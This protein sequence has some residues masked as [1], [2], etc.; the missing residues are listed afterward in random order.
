MRLIEGSQISVGKKKIINAY[1]FD[2]KNMLHAL[3]YDNGCLKVL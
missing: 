2:H 1:D 3:G